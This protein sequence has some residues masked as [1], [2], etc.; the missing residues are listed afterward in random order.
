M[1]AQTA[2]VAC[3]FEAGSPGGK[4]VT[5]GSM[6]NGTVI[7]SPS[8]GVAANTTV[9]LTVIPG[10]GYIYTDDSL[11]VND[12]A[13]PLT[14]IASSGGYKRWTF[15]MPEAPVT[16][17]CGFEVTL[18]SADYADKNFNPAL[19]SFYDKFE[20]IGLDYAKWGHQNGNGS[21]YGENGWGNQEL[22]SY[23]T[24]NAVVEGGILKLAAKRESDNGKNFTSAKLVTA[25]P[26]G[27][28]REPPA[29]VGIKFGQTYGRFEAKIRLTKV[30]QGAWPAF[31]MM[32]V[33]SA[34]G[35]WPRSGEIDIM[36]MT[37][38]RPTHT[39]STVHVKPNWGTWESQY[40]G[41]GVTFLDG[42][43]FTDWHVFGVLWTAAEMSFLVD[44]YKI[45]TRYPM[46]PS[47]WNTDWYKNEGHPATAPFDRDFHLILNLALDSGRYGGPANT[48]PPDAQTADLG[49][50]EVE[51]VR[52]YTIADDPWPA[53]E[54]FPGATDVHSN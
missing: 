35:G 3:D 41:G 29:G 22:Q 34:Y 16:V 53:P 26:K 2:A 31:W 37:G 42:S 47:W 13:A 4:N 36:E 33:N 6:T 15:S 32:P 12:G 23:K 27:T 11:K 8:V 50:M 39:G 10:S 28:S 9:T 43:D 38:S 5:I 20:G 1:P 14:A 19:C 52:C 51:W 46:Q 44:G 21:D 30:F 48:L 7:A 40:Q 24:A 49:D 17:T 25:N 18:W 45:R 54:A